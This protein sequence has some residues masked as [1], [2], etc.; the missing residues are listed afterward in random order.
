MT[1]STRALLATL[2]FALP[3]LAQRNITLIEAPSA[4]GQ[5]AE[6]W[7][8]AFAARGAVVHVF[9]EVDGKN[10]FKIERPSSGVT[11]AASGLVVTLWSLVQEA[12]QAE[13]KRI[14]VQRG[15]A[16]KTKLPAKLLARAPEHDLALLQVELP[17]GASW[18]AARLDL[19]AHAGDPCAVLSLPEGDD[20][21]GF[22]G[23]V[24]EPQAG[25]RSSDGRSLART[26]FLLTDAA[27]QRRN[28][29]G[30]LLSRRG[31]LLGLCSADRVAVEVSEPTLEDLKRPSFGFVIPSRSIATAF[32]AQLGDAKPRDPSPPSDAA[33]LLARLADGVV[34]VH[35]GKGEGAR[36][37]VGDDDPFG[38]RRRPGVGSGV[39]V[40]NNG[41]I[42]TNRHLVQDAQVI[43]VTRRDGKSVSAKLL[44]ED[45]RG[46]AALLAVD[47]AAGLAWQPLACAR[48]DS[49]A[50]GTPL[51]ALGNP[52]GHTLS[53]ARGVLSAIRDSRLQ[54]DAAIGN[55]NGGGA[56][57]TLRGELIGMC[58]AGR[59]DAIDLAFAMRGDQAKVDTSLNM[60]P[61]IELLRG[62]FETE[63][64]KH[65]D[66]QASILAPGR[67]A[68]DA[69]PVADVVERVGL[70]ML[71]I[72]VEI[73][74]APADVEDNPFAQGTGKTTTEGL[75]SGVVVDA[76]G[77]ALTN[78][79][80][81]DSAT[82]P[83]GSMRRDRAVRASLRDGRSFAARVLSISREED[84]ALL[85]LELGQGDTLPAVQLGSSAQ[86][87]VG[88]LA[89]AIGNPM[90]RANTV[91]AGIVT[92]KNQAI[93]VKGRWA[94]L[95]NLFETDAAINA[96]NS[97]GALLDRDGR[98][99]GINSAGGSL[100]AVT[101][102]A[103][104]VDHVR[105]RLRGLLLS[106]EKLRS[107]Y[108]GLVVTDSGG[109][110]VVQNV[111]GSGPAH[112]LEVA[113]GDRV[114][115]V[116]ARSVASSIDFALAALDAPPGRA[117]TVRLQRGN[118]P[119]EVSITPLTAEAWA[120]VRQTGLWLEH[121]GVQRDAAT[122]HA[123]ALAFYRHV[124]GDP[125]AA[126]S[127]LPEQL[128]RVAK[129]LPSA[130]DRKTGLLV[131]D[132]LLGV[133]HRQDAAG[134]DAEQLIRCTA[135]GDVQRLV[136]GK[137]SYEGDILR[138]Y[139]FRGGAVK[140]VDLPAKR[141]ML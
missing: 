104:A 119:R 122:V 105:E 41:L 42:L 4:R 91:T 51:L 31:T 5:G 35:A 126:P 106:P 98:L 25:I 37:P 84:L 116:G 24:A 71:N 19:G 85:Q 118:S 40:S 131:G 36:A 11:I 88:D 141:L 75:G 48:A 2:S 68:A 62:A 120:V 21:I 103:I 67:A 43:T 132:I 130:L 30:A 87:A 32:A 80:V 60:V 136:N 124:T 45:A 72:Y 77:L 137:C 52:E 110:A 97:G 26:D 46:N 63:L 129:V 1:P 140:L 15:D 79:H 69:G 53:I 93:R 107:P 7:A 28:H 92:A 54:T 27:I 74:S 83:D 47:A 17:A 18:P 117:L 58:D 73:T 14:W 101:G 99:I 23:V 127:E 94:K 123:A 13:D 89:I 139:V 55:H 20:E 81:V 76:S 57:V 86:L 9:V 33:Q 111:D 138:A 12:E 65:A 29:G 56:L 64:T 112:G 113:A 38:Q 16:Q 115:G 49:V 59:R 114:V 100:H 108:L 121:I 102:F 133:E 134:A 135:I 6:P 10:R 39:V 70:A 66:A 128:P 61:S 90:G 125:Q 3:C 44:G 109:H 50:V 8:E 96:G 95:K 34:A 78:W 82:E 22:A